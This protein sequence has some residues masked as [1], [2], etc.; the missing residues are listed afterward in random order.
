VRADPDKHL[1][2]KQ[3]VGVY[4]AVALQY[5]AVVVRKVQAVSTSKL[6]AHR[7]KKRWQLVAENEKVR[8]RGKPE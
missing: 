5:F 1:N 2:S 3:L 6:E 4:D 8:F 7:R